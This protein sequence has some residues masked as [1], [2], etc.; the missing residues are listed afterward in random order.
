MA[1]NSISQVKL[2]LPYAYG[3]AKTALKTVQKYLNVPIDYYA[4]I[5]MG[6]LENLINAVGGLDIKPLIT[7]SY[8]NQSF[9]KDQTTHM[10]GKRGLSLRADAR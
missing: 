10:N 9:T 2:T 8:D 6:G 4:T 5:N 7:F 1:T 3:G